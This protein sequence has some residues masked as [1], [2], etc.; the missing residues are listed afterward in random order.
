[1][2]SAENPRLSILYKGNVINRAPRE[3]GRKTEERTEAQKQASHPG[4]KTEE[5][6]KRE[7]KL[8]SRKKNGRK[9]E[10]KRKD[11]KVSYFSY[12]QV[13]E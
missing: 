12:F 6:R 5:K 8:I 4:R 1:M 9:T 11:Q 10:D 3:N 7:R 2:T 13:H